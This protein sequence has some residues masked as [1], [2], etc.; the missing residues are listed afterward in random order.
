M[1]ISI[2]N[3][4]WTIYKEEKE[5]LNKFIFPKNNQFYIWF[6]PSIGD[7]FKKIEFLLHLCHIFYCFDYKGKNAF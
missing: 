4:P 1:P 2:L 5:N 7:K 3:K 6:Y